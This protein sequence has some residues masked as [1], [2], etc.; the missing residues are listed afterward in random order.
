MAILTYS[1]QKVTREQLENCIRWCQN[2][3]NL[4]D[5]KISLITDEQ[6]FE[7]SDITENELGSCLSNSDFL[8]AILWIPLLKH[9]KENRN[10][11]QTCIHEMIHVLTVGAGRIESDKSEIVSYRL[12]SLLYKLYCIEHKLKIVDENED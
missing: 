10:S 2:K 12:D 8:K 7:Q 6:G 5:W 3:F 4:R 1:Y 9:K 11:Y